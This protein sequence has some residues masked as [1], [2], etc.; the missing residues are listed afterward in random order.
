MSDETRTPRVVTAP[1]ESVVR[2]IV[3]VATAL[4]GLLAMLGLVAAVPGIDRLVAGVD[5]S[6]T[7]LALAVVVLLVVGALLGVAPEIE[8]GVK[9]SLDGPKGVVA[10]AAVAAK[11]LVG[12]LAVVVAYHGFGPAV[13]PTFRAFGVGGLYHLGFLVVGLAVLAALARRLYH[14][15]G[16]LTRVV[17]KYVIDA[18]EGP[19]RRAAS[20]R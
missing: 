8:R 16:P 6:P 2:R 13:T 10:N 19:S 17:T 3:R 1:D 7:A 5:V 14:C 11:L 18:A 20:E 9:R 4:V 12:F 15:W